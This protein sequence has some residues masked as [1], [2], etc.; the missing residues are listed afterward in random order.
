MPTRPK[1][2]CPVCRKLGCTDPAHKPVPWEHSTSRPTTERRPDYAK[3]QRRRKAVVDAHRAEFGNWCP[4]CNDRD[5]HADGKRVVLTAD[6]V[7][8]VADEGAEQG[9]L[10]VMCRRCNSHLGGKLGA[11][12]ARQRRR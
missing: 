4:R 1:P 3:D 8:S 2:A 10:R 12:I 5:Y 7:R 6:H 11:K 9:L